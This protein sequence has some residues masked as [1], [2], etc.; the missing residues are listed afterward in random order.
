MKFRQ[1]TSCRCCHDF[2]RRTLTLALLLACRQPVVAACL[3]VARASLLL[4]PEC[5]KKDV[6]VKFGPQHL[7]VSVA[8]HPLQPTV[9]DADLLYPIR[10]GECA[11]AL[12][13]KGVKLTQ[14]VLVKVGIPLP[15]S[16]HPAAA[17]AGGRQK[18]APGAAPLRRWGSREVGAVCQCATN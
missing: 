6:A 14:D 13:G 1:T 18:G 2:V 7:T 3:P 16:D 9:L 12:E 10:P 15:G 11:W 5:V 17:S 8:G 4:P